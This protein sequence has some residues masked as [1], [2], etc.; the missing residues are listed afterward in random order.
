MGYENLWVFYLKICMESYVNVEKINGK[1]RIM[2][3]MGIL[4]DFV[5][6]EVSNV[7]YDGNLRSYI[8]GRLEQLIT[9][10]ISNV[11]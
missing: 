6:W 7:F 11:F 1:D 8:M 4:L 5:L 3:F 2:G 9:Y 10:T